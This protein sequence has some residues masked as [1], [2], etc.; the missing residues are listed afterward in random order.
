VTCGDG[1][2]TRTRT[3]TNPAQ[4]NGGNDCSEL[5][6]AENIATCNIIDCPKPEVGGEGGALISARA[7]SQLTH[8]HCWE[9]GD[10]TCVW[11][12]NWAIDGEIPTEYGRILHSQSSNLPWF[13][14]ELND[15]SIILNVTINN[16]EDCC[17]ERFKNAEIRAG[18][19]R[20]PDGTTGPLDINTICGTYQ[21]P[22]VQ[23]DVIRIDCAS[24]ITA[25][26]V[27]VQLKDNDATLQI[28]EIRMNIDTSCNGG[29]HGIPCC[30]EFVIGDM[31]GGD[32]ENIEFSPETPAGCQ[33]ACKVQHPT[34]IGM[35]MNADESECWCEFGT[36]EFQ[37]DTDWKTCLFST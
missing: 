10:E 14:V 1:R 23:G 21:G 3:C 19:T 27:T 30:Q 26:Y 8:E 2:K 16:R 35:T 28:S 37:E 17:G 36:P 4:A 13:E 12:A 34:S 22:S 25:K 11:G 33:S 32:E 20:V 6:E 31:V 18:M 29:D 5:G 15:P 9:T 7:S 24:P